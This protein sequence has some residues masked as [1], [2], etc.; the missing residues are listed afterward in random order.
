MIFILVKFFLQ[1]N[2]GTTF[3]SNNSYYTN[4]IHL[5]CSNAVCEN[6]TTN[7]NLLLTIFTFNIHFSQ[8]QEILT[9][10]DKLL[11]SFSLFRNEMSDSYKTIQIYRNKTRVE[12]VDAR[13]FIVIRVTRNFCLE[14]KTTRELQH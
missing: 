3:C 10:G 9:F 11:L 1:N 13:Y 14:R 5:F 12:N 7:Y 8:T 2:Q 6:K 4:N